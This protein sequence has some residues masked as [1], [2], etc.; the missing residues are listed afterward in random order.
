VGSV[1]FCGVMCY[2]LWRCSLVWERVCGLWQLGRVGGGVLWLGWGLAGVGLWVWEAVGRWGFGVAWVVWVVL[3][4][5][6]L[7][8][9]G[10]VWGVGW[11]LGVV[12]VLL[13]VGLCV[14]LFLFCGWVGLGMVWCGGVGGGV[15]SWVVVGAGG[16]FPLVV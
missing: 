9:F 15:W 14:F 2:K 1:G 8:G 5:R 11:C 16:V 3:G 6:L 13:F 10:G 12:F 4:Q 7:L